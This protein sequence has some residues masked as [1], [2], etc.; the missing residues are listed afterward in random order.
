MTFDLANVI[1]LMGSALMV[2]AYAYSNMA[3]TL[4]FVIFNAMN[5]VGA[6]LLIWSLT[7]HFNLASMALEVVWAAIAL[8]GLGN[9]LKGKKR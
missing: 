9:A 1:G 4:N 2:V 5:L 8:L 6:L 3:K 7:V